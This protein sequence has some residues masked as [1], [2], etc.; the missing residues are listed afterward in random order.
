MAGKAVGGLAHADPEL[1]RDATWFL[2]PTEN[3][4]PQA[5][6]FLRQW[7][8]EIGGKP[9]EIE[10]EEHDHAVALTSHVPHV[11][12]NLLAETV[13]EEGALDA[14]GGTLRK[15]LEVAGA[16]FDVWGDTLSTNQKAILQSMRHISSKISILA[17][18]ME[19]PDRLR[20][21]FARGRAC[22]ERLRG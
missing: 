2:C 7:I 16:P 12:I 17:D 6:G 4:E 21:L 8:H 19:D 5:L 18:E 1:L 10:A 22:R 3:S 20:D 9:L 13:L 11:L 15:V 14:A